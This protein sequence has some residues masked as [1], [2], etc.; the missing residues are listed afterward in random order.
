ML[1]VRTPKSLHCCWCCVN[2]Q[3]EICFQD[4]LTNSAISNKNKKFLTNFKSE[5]THLR[6][7]APT[8]D[9]DSVY[10]IIN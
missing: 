1:C 9:S 2:F 4:I 5:N 3:F 7:I 8:F 10:L 6:I